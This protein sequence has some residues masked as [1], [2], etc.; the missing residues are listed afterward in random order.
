M[1]KYLRYTIPG[2]IVIAIIAWI[3][4]SYIVKHTIPKN[5]EYATGNTAGN[6][7]SGGL[8]CEYDDKIFFA[9]PYDSYRLYSMNPDCSNIECISEDSASYINAYGK[10][11]YYIKNNTTATISS[12]IFRSELCGV[13]RCKRDGSRDEVLY[14][15]YSTD[16]SLSGNSLIYNSRRNLEMVTY[17]I[18]TNGKK[19]TLIT[20]ADFSNA[21]V[22]NGLLYYSNSENNHA[23]YSMDIDDG[24]SA[25]FYD[26]NTYMANIINNKMYYIDLDNNYALTCIDLLTY[27]RQVLTNDRVVLYNVYNNVIYYQ[28]ENG[29]HALIRMNLDGS[30]K[31]TIVEGDITT[32]HCTSLYTFFQMYGSETLYRIETYNGTDIQKFYIMAS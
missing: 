27:E 32:I 8:F 29:T 25:L 11:V 17:R 6:L 21:S 4:I 30:D 13:V 3:L 28:K 7:N 26:G 1:K 23:I 12:V 22:Y 20:A 24:V 14:K 31:E 19:N 16:L 2:A 9:N 15:G 18:G 10:Y 5:P